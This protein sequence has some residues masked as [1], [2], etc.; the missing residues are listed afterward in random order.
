[1]IHDRAEWRDEMSKWPPIDY[2]S[3]YNYFVNTP[4]MYP[5]ESLK[6]YTSRDSYVLRQDTHICNERQG[7]KSIIN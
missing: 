5:V 4:G 7:S 2:G 3:M 6:P 1:M